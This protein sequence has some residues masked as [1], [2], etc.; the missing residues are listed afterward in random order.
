MNK[1]TVKLYGVNW[2]M[3]LALASLVTFAIA[4][5]ADDGGSY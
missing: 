4:G 1:L 2:R 3:V 5:A